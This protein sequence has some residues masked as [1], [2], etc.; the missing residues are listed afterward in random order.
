[1]L[2][3]S[4]HFGQ[5]AKLNKWLNFFIVLIYNDRNGGP[6]NIFSFICTDILLFGQ[7]LAVG[8]KCR[9]YMR[10]WTSF[11]FGRKS[12]P[13]AFYFAG[14]GCCKGNSHRPNPLKRTKFVLYL[15]NDKRVCVLQITEFF[16]V[17]KQSNLLWNIVFFSLYSIYRSFKVL[18]FG[19]KKNS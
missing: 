2:N 7:E 11:L 15:Y 6:F 12:Q 18:Q 5:T 1:M 10:E 9:L 19:F 8:R 16:S 17:T 4:K 3:F 13:N 14:W